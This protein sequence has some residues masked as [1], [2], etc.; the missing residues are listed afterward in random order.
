MAVVK[1]EKVES[2]RDERQFRPE[3]INDRIAE[4]VRVRIWNSF[5]LGVGFALGALAASLVP[6][7]LAAFLALWFLGG[8]MK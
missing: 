6:L 5:E 2:S 4:V 3:Q 7:L 8:M 1:N